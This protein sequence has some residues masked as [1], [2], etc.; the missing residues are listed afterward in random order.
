MNI[1]Q[2]RIITKDFEKFMKDLEKSRS[3]N[4][5]GNFTGIPHSISEIL[6]ACDVEIEYYKSK[7]ISLDN[8]NK[9]I[10]T[11]DNLNS[12]ELIKESLLYVFNK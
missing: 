2:A 8:K 4:T 6:T 12:R 10:E 1:I 5:L 11:Q 7:I 3:S 9:I